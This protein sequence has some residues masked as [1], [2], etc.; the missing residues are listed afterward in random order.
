MYAL[1]RLRPASIRIRDQAVQAIPLPALEIKLDIEVRIAVAH[2]HALALHRYLGDGSNAFRLGF[3]IRL[4]GCY[5]VSRALG[6]VC[7]LDL[8]PRILGKDTVHLAGPSGGEGRPEVIDG[9]L[10][11]LLLDAPG[12]LVAVLRHEGRGM[13]SGVLGKFGRLGNARTR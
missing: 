12:R 9:L 8:G 13:K 4:D 10:G 3:V 6:L 1:D 2:V 5:S 7:R 11:H